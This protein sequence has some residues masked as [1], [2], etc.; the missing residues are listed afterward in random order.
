MLC[1]PSHAMTKEEV[2]VTHPLT[3]GSSGEI[4]FYGFSGESSQALM[5]VCQGMRS[6]MTDREQQGREERRG[7]VLCR[8]PLR[9]PD[10][11][12]PQARSPVLV[13]WMLE[14]PDT[15]A[16]HRARAVMQAGVLPTCPT[17]PLP[18]ALI[19]KPET[20]L[21][22][23]ELQHPMGAELSWHSPPSVPKPGLFT[24]LQ[25]RSDTRAGGEVG[26][27]RQEPSS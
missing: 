20:S 7:P 15:D 27:A 4:L 16:Q 23:L 25:N 14:V 3:E 19:P 24:S 10:P 9:H 1:Y 2:G 22:G 12:S 8:R 26:T 17:Q 6:T 5:C 11:V 13:P 21:Q 18:P